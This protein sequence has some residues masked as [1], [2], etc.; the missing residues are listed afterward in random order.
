MSRKT[1]QLI[2][3]EY[4]GWYEGISS[5]CVIDV[6][7]LD[8]KSTHRLRGELRAKGMEIRVLKNSL[9]RRAFEG[10]ALEPLGKSLQGPC[11]LVHG[12]DSAVDVA[13]ELVRLA[14]EMDAIKLKVGMIDG[15]PE[16][17][18]V[19]DMAQMKSRAEL[20]G[21]VIMLVLSPWRR[22]AGQITSPWAKVAGC[23]K[24]VADKTEESQAA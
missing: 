12:G 5:A 14:R 16:L 7:G 8:A 6:T 3:D 19:K 24:A 21:E 15:D 10:A 1:K 22:V 18:P 17:M 4:K 13:K 20:Q 11:T 23:V 9:A 2:T